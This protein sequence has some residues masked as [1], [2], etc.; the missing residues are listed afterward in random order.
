MRFPFTQTHC[1]AAPCGG[2]LRWIA[3]ILASVLTFSIPAQA[4]TL[5]HVSYDPSRE[6]Y[7]AY[8]AQF[9]AT[10]PDVQ[11]RQ[12]HGGSAKQARAVIDGLQADVVSLAL[13]Y[14]IDAIAEKSGFLPTTWA[15]SFPH[16]SVPMHSV[17]VLLVRKGNPKHIHDWDDLIRDGIDVITPNPKTSGG[18]RWNYLAAYAHALR[19]AKG[20]RAAAETFIAALYKRVKVLDTGARGATMTFVQ[21]RIGDVLIAWESEAYLAKEQLGAGEFEIVYPRLTIR[22]DT[23]VAVVTRRAEAK[24]TAAL[25]RAYVSGLFE[26]AAQQLA[27]QHYFRPQDP[28]VAA[29]FSNQFP[30][31]T[32]ISIEDL[33][34]WKH[35]HQ[36]H[37][38][39]G[40]MFD[41]V[42]GK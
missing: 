30:S 28:S 33:G 35:A 19:A 36:E 7:E 32:S 40:A 9:S 6:F 29:R 10:H 17:I 5:L 42:Y 11:I 38:A 26:P 4:A 14:D 37:F 18:A 13:A 41:R 34:G 23:P 20:D 3:S 22:A 24:G 1:T 39:H 8:N 16:Q 31:V 15:Q 12:S 2:V 21:R 25:A 27:A